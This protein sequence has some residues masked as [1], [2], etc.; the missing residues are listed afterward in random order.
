MVLQI[1]TD[2]QSMASAYR[3]NGLKPPCGTRCYCAFRCGGGAD[4]QLPAFRGLDRAK[5]PSLNCSGPICRPWALAPREN[6]NT[7][8]GPPQNESAD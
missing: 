7:A 1:D 3:P 6:V 4:D 2:R 8:E 5:K